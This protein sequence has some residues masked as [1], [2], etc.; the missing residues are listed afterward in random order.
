MSKNLGKT[1]IRNLNKL[2]LVLIITIVSFFCSSINL[3]IKYSNAYSIKDFLQSLFET[4]TQ[5]V[6]ADLPNVYLGGIPLGF[7]LDCDGVIVV[8]VG[9][10]HSEA[11]VVNT[12]ISGDIEAGDVVTHINGISITSVKVIEEQMELQE[13][14]NTQ[15]E[16]KIQD[17]NFSQTEAVILP[18]KDVITGKYKLGLWVRDN[19]AGVGTLTYVREDNLKF[20]A[21]GHSVCDIDTGRMLPLLSGNV[22]KCNIIGVNPS[23]KGTAGELK[24]LF[25]R[26]GNVIGSVEKNVSCGVFGTAEEEL[27]SL[28]TTKLPVASKS[29]VKTGRASIY[30]C[31]EGGKV[32]E[33]SIEIIKTTRQ[34]KEDNKSMI[35]RITDKELIDKTGG[36]VQGMSGSPIVQNGMLVGAVTHVLV[37]DPTKG[38]GIFAQTMI[39]NEN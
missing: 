3:G 16:L 25:L 36:I 23:K 33:Y 35:I 37:S 24:G 22:Y 11:G 1:F 4:P 39:E 6:S 13:K 18:A 21:L 15:V 28:L 26:N 27:V 5:Q 10:V 7:T 34:S 38:Y 30:C 20:G 32:Q 17:K 12:I 31:V 14:Q 19:S 29:Q 9:Q 2:L 8:A